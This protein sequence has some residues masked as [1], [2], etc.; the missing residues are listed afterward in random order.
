MRKVNIKSKNRE[1][2]F[3]NLKE[4]MISEGISPLKVSYSEESIYLFHELVAQD[5]E[6]KFIL[7]FYEKEKT[8]AILLASETQKFLICTNNSKSAVIPV[9][10]SSNHIQHRAIMDMFENSFES[11]NT[12]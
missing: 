1:D 11:L 7:N 9:S 5:Y 4:I 2:F 10:D 3:E 8:K 6:P 12:L